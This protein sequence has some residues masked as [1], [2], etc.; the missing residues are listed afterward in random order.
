MVWVDGHLDLAYLAVTGRDLRA[1]ADGTTGCVS[2][3]ALRRARIDVVLGTVYTAPGEDGAYGYRDVNDRTGARRAGVAQLDVY[4]TLERAGELTIVRSPA[5]L[6]APR[7]APAVVL[8]MEGAD[9]IAGP[10]DVAWWHARGLRFVGLTWA[11]G[12][13][14]AGGNGR[15]GPLTAEGVDLVRA[16]DAE[17]IVHD[18]SHLA[19]EAFDG[20]LEHATGRVVATH[21]NCR[22]LLAD[23]MRH[24]RDD[25]IR[26]IDARDGIVGLNLY[27]G[28]LAT[29]RRANVADCVDH[30]THVAEVMG[31]RRGVALGSDMDGG[32][33]PDDLPDGCDRPGLLD[34]LAAALRNA[35]WSDDDVAGFTAGNWMRFLRAIM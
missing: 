16:L 9:P 2:L 7:P 31:H 32:F 17:R 10:D 11:R 24:L 13:R 27:A 23:D 3:P 5:D 21:S 4:E 15:G 34:T 29:G 33:G 22:A 14:Y 12:T 25:Q 26:A 30:V 20:L 6:D 8:L 18:A 35:G 1:E 28:F 19:D